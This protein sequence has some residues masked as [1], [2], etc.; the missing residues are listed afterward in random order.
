MFSVYYGFSELMHKV[1]KYVDTQYVSFTSDKEID[2]L[3]CGTPS[4]HHIQ[5]L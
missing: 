3:T 1:V 5:K 4:C 2:V